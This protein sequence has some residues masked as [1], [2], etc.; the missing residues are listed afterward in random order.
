MQQ[1][2]SC[3]IKKDSLQKDILSAKSLVTSNRYVPP[4][5]SVAFVDSTFQLLPLWMLKI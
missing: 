5:V 2:I 1:G 3:H 4:D